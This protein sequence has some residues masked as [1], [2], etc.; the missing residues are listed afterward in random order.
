MIA[1][2]SPKL[3]FALAFAALLAFIGV[4]RVQ[5]SSAKAATANVRL[6]LAQVERAYADAARVAQTAADQVEAAHLKQQLKAE[7]DANTRE[8][9][10]RADAAGANDA[11]GRLRIAIRAAAARSN[12]VPGNATVATGVD[13][14][15]IGELFAQCS[16]QLVGVASA[17]DG[18]ISDVETLRESW[19][20]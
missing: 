6:N 10:L 4:Q 20:K 1:L 17:A 18:A 2:L 11:L 7:T 8:T 9:G 15:A 19:P 14:G 12:P 3:W 5:V 13:G 16:A